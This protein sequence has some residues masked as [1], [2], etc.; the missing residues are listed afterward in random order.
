MGLVEGS[1]ICI[2]TSSSGVNSPVT[3]TPMPCRQR[4]VERPQTCASAPR[5]DA[6]TRTSESNG[7]RTLRRCSGWRPLALEPNMAIAGRDYVPDYITPIRLGMVANYGR[8]NVIS[9]DRTLESTLCSKSWYLSHS[10][11]GITY[12][13][14][15]V[16]NRLIADR[17]PRLALLIFVNLRQTFQESSCFRLQSE[18]A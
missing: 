1:G 8:G 13:S 17:G 2:A 4:S 10:P 9:A 3:V 5:R 12:G 14:P 15:P 7:K 6:V 11:H 16:Q 18:K